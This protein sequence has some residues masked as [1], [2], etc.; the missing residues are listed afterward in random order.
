MTEPNSAMFVSRER[1]A[2]ATSGYLM[3]ALFVA[4]IALLVWRF[5]GF[6]GTQP[7]DPAQVGR[8]VVGNIA[9]VIVLILIAKGF[10]MI[11]PNQA[12]AITLFGSYRGTDRNTGLRWIWP[13]MG[14]RKISVRA[15]NLISERI[16]VTDLRGNPI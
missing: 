13:W 11:Q 9:G 10:Y 4:L 2:W 1:G 15:N 8:F 5:F 12:V 3:L 14:K 6:A 7:G 16:K